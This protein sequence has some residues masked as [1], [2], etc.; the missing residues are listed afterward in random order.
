MESEIS[1]LGLIGNVV[2]Y[3]DIKLINLSLICSLHFVRE[4]YNAL[5]GICAYM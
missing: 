2:L 3:R 1:I 4:I 5:I